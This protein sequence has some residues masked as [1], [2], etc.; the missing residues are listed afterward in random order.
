MRAKLRGVREA[1]VGRMVVSTTPWCTYSEGPGMLRSRL[2]AT[3]LV[4]TC[5]ACSQNEA[6]PTATPSP[7]PTQST[8][9]SSSPP[10]TST[11][12]PELAGYSAKEQAAYDAAVSEYDTFITRN[13]AFYA[14]GKTTTDAKTF[15][16]KFS[17]DWATAWGNLAQVA[18]N[19]VK[20]RGDATA[21]WTKPQSID[22]KDNR[23]GVIVLRRCLDESGRIVAQNGTRLDQPQ[24]KDP[25][26]YRI[27]LEKR[28][29]EG[30]WRSG[31]AEQGK[32]C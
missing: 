11:V 15:F 12:A 9:S 17:I 7:S 22:L 10:P 14:A 31:I 13:D 3:L 19:G 4:L 28:A 26:V 24:F 29:G 21:V 27:G 18:N 5:A 23:G 20:V 32:T 2:V 6:S 25:H 16:Q 30:W 8:P 1:R